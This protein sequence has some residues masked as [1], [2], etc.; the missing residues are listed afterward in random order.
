MTGYHN[1]Y[2]FMTKIK[3]MLSKNIFLINPD[4]NNLVITLKSFK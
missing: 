3:Y 1:L 4:T 2:H